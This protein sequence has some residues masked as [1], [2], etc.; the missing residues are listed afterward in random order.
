MFND[1]KTL[2]MT[3]LATFKERLLFFIHYMNMT[4]KAFEESI[5]VSNS[6]IANLRKKMGDDILNNTLTA[7]PQL[8]RIWLLTGEGE[9]LNSPT[10]IS[11]TN[12][13]TI[14]GNM[15]VANSITHPDVMT[16]QP[17][18]E[19]PPFDTIYTIYSDAMLP[20][21]KIGDKLAL[22]ATNHDVLNNRYYVVETKTNGKIFC[23]LTKNDPDFI[24]KYDNKEYLPDF[25]NH[26]D[27]IRIYRV[28]GQIRITL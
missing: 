9:M 24:A 16:E 17:K 27:V 7:Y 18:I 14:G 1:Y 12:N 23:R 28:V 13:G 19:L 8:N 22:K 21:F 15:N 4:N 5:G 2:N 3:K 6:Y 10:N 20:D 26:E 11:A 25:I